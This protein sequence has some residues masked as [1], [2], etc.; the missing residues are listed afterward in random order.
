MKKILLSLLIASFIGTV[1]FNITSFARENQRHL[2]NIIQLSGANNSVYALD[3]TGKLW[4]WGYNQY[5]NLGL[6]DETDRFAPTRLHI[7]TST[8]ITQIGSGRHI[9]AALNTSGQVFSW[10]EKWPGKNEAQSST[11]V[12][13]NGFS[14]IKQIAVGANFVLGLDQSG[15]VQL[16]GQTST[17]D[18]ASKFINEPSAI[19][20]T[21]EHIVSIAA[22]QNHGY[23]LTSEGAVWSIS[24]TSSSGSIAAK[25]TLLPDLKN[26]KMISSG[27]KAIACIDS[28]EHGW[29]YDQDANQVVKVPLTQPIKTI[30]AQPINNAAII[31]S[32]G[33]VYQ[34]ISKTDTQLLKGVPSNGIAAIQ[35]PL[36][37]TILTK[38]GEVWSTGVN[39]NG[40]LGIA[41][42][43]RRIATAQ[44]AIQPIQLELNG[45]LLHPV[46][47]PKMVGNYVY[48][49]IRGVLQEMGSTV[50]WNKNQ[51]NLVKITSKNTMIQ[52]QVDQ[53]YAMING[54]AVQLDAPVVYIDGSMF[55]PLRFI[56]QAEGATVNW[57]SNLYTVS[58]SFKN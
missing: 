14:G 40:Q 46:N 21:P 22:S 52:L 49:P 2:S 8:S 36:A 44:P 57:D 37:T 4:I 7:P 38:S 42:N 18:N 28:N 31:T 3:H 26:I 30:S 6:G 48:V 29:I 35:N 39:V 27:E 9:N 34:L 54:K 41:N 45:T 15:K 11:P 58:I 53:K 51:K 24:I 17:S 33:N 1:S 43:I 5:G 50:N 12:M 20:N 56:S 23:V 16:W 47:S 10:S 19:P 55:V 13:I 32:N 25:P